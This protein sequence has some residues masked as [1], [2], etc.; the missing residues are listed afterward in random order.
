MVAATVTQKTTT[1]SWKVLNCIIYKVWKYYFWDHGYITNQSLYFFGFINNKSQFSLNNQLC[2]F[3]Q[4]LGCYALT[5]FFYWEC[6]D[7]TSVILHRGSRVIKSKLLDIYIMIAF[8]CSSQ[9]CCHTEPATS[10]TEH[11]VLLRLEM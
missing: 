6:E 8:M 11:P 5:I 4:T 1:A 10:Q 9:N 3:K 2:S 7:R